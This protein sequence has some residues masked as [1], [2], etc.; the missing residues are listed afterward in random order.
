MNLSPGTRH[1]QTI[2]AHASNGQMVKA[3]FPTASADLESL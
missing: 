3:D 2:S 1:A